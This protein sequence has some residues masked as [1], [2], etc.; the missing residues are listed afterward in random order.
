MLGARVAALYD[1]AA[2]FGVDEGSHFSAR[3]RPQRLST[4]GAAQTNSARTATDDEA[5]MES[6]LV[7]IKKN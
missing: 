2:V 5:C 7:E 4:R 6:S 3:R 1:D